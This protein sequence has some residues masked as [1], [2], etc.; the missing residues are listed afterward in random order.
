VLQGSIKLVDAGEDSLAMAIA[1]MIVT[2]LVP[3]ALFLLRPES[4]TA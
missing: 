2:A 1:W 3:W 4:R